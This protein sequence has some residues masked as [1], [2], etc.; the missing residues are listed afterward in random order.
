M[1]HHERGSQPPRSCGASDAALLQKYVPVKLSEEAPPA[2]ENFP[3][4][5]IHGMSPWHAAVAET[6]ET[7][8]MN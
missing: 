6:K 8:I 2:Q 5:R 3:P 7:K 4:H 1:V